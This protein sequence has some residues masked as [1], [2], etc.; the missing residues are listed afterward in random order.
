MEDAPVVVVV[1]VVKGL[2]RDSGQDRWSTRPR[3]TVRCYT[4]TS[5]PS[6]HWPATSEMLLDS[7]GRPGLPPSLY[8]RR[9]SH[10]RR[11]NSI[12]LALHCFPSF[13]ASIFGVM[14]IEKKESHSP[15]PSVWAELAW[16]SRSSLLCSTCIYNTHHS[17]DNLS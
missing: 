8:P 16:T 12:T 13:S 5:P 9:I 1:V 7:K 2:E 3:A 14:N 4:V 6:K 10:E 17:N 15:D 11:G